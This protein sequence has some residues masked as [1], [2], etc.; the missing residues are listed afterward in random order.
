MRFDA[1]IQDAALAGVPHAPPA[2]IGPASAE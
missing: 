2:D 1:A